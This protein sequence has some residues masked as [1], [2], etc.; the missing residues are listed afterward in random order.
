[1]KNLSLLF[2]SFLFCSISIFSQSEK[3][4]DTTIGVADEKQTNN[5]SNVTAKLGG[6]LLSEGILE[7]TFPD[8]SGNLHP[9][10][11]A[12]DGTFYYVVGGGNAPGDVAMLDEDFNLI[13]T[14]SVDLDCRSVF[15]NP[16]DDEVYIKAYTN[17]TSA[18]GNN[19]PPATN[20]L[21]SAIPLHKFKSVNNN[22]IPLPRTN[23]YKVKSKSLKEFIIKAI[24]KNNVVEIEGI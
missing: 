5:V 17:N 16:N 24:T 9:I 8:Y 22:A 6:P 20:T 7:T 10:S 18:F 12:F 1:M 2:A 3:I 19:I 23:K 21:K 15:Y 11:I 4:F 13:T 14:Q